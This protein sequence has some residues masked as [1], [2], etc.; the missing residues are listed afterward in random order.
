MALRVLWWGWRPH[1]IY[2]FSKNQLFVN[3]FSLYDQWQSQES[4]ISVKM[5][6]FPSNCSTS[7]PCYRPWWPWPSLK[8]TPTYAVF[9]ML[10]ISRVHFFVRMHCWVST[11]PN[12]WTFLK[13]GHFG[14][15]GLLTK[16]C[17]LYN[18]LVY[19][20]VP[21]EILGLKNQLRPIWKNFF[22]VPTCPNAK[23][24]KSVFWDFRPFGR[25]Y[26]V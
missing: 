18:P 12:R 11:L 6:L 21:S 13:S 25:W 10:D 16:V 14:Q 24:P 3:I 9:H 20:M 19:F 2:N 17:F 5:W 22:I 4:S 23:W 7:L 8:T 1:T 26:L 15:V